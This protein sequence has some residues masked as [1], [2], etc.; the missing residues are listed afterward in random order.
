[1]LCET[2]AV[3]VILRA[4][5][6]VV[7]CRTWWRI[8]AR[9]VARRPGRPREGVAGLWLAQLVWRGPV[10]G[11]SAQFTAVCPIAPA[12]RREFQLFGLR[13]Q[14][15]KAVDVAISAS[16]NCWRSTK[17]FKAAIDAARAPRTA[18][19]RSCD[20]TGVAGERF[21]HAA[22]AQ[23]RG[24]DVAF[25][26]QQIRLRKRGRQAFEC[27]VV[28]LAVRANCLHSGVGIALPSAGRGPDGSS[29]C[30]VI[31]PFSCVELS[32]PSASLRW[33]R[34]V[35]AFDSARML[36]RSAV[37]TRCERR[38]RFHR[39][40]SCRAS[41]QTSACDCLHRADLQST[42]CRASSN[43]ES[44]QALG[45][46]Q[47]CTSARSSSVRARD[48]TSTTEIVAAAPFP[49]SGLR[50]RQACIGEQPVS[51]ASERVVRGELCVQQLVENVEAFVELAAFDKTL[52]QADTGRRSSRCCGMP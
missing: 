15:R 31:E 34:R 8:A 17:S 30:R 37:A 24:L 28:Q 19:A 5:P 49:N 9:P 2:V 21:Q 42:L 20:T 45:P 46:L 36:P 52:A 44:R 6:Q 50:H 38:I 47:E 35:F 23:H 22:I 26:A 27:V 41:G 16:A 13:E 39:D 14:R 48:S 40:R 32:A 1:M 51:F 11:D 29:T 7:R 43:V 4:L 25:L 10:V 33:P 18:A 3:E 12:C